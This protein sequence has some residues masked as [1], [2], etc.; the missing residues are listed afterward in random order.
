MVSLWFLALV[1]RQGGGS[2]LPSE[3]TCQPIWQALDESGSSAALE[4]LEQLTPIDGP[5][6]EVWQLLKAALLLGQQ[7]PHES[8]LLALS[9]TPYFELNRPGKAAAYLIASEAA[10]TLSR[11]PDAL[12]LVTKAQEECSFSS[13]RSLRLLLCLIRA[14][15]ASH[16]GSPEEVSYHLASARRIS[17]TP[18]QRALCQHISGQAHCEAGDYLGSL[19]AFHFV[20]LHGQTLHQRQ[21]AAAERQEAAANSLNPKVSSAKRHLQLREVQVRLL[22]EVS[23]IIDGDYRAVPRFAQ[24][25]LLL[26]YL[27]THAG[28]G[29]GTVA[30]L[31]LPQRDKDTDLDIK[32]RQRLDAYRLASLLTSAREV[33]NDPA[34]ILSSGGVL[35]L[36]GRYRL[37]S[38]LNRELEAGT[39]RRQRLPSGLTCHWLDDLET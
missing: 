12:R 23:I 2:F 30:T 5:H 31:L 26:C 19:E 25:L 17:K 3:A 36:S 10:L 35:S 27:E 6:L 13:A 29:R 14:K 39:Y 7:Q 37:S 21:A 32:E 28:A 18:A 9:T 33:L 16:Q 38:D 24:A 4:R 22:D 20:E 15:L 1:S 8:L 34:S 11:L